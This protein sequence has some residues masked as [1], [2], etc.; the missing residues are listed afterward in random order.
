[1]S[2]KQTAS[3]NAAQD[4]IPCTSDDWLRVMEACDVQFGVLSQNQDEELIEAL[5]HR[6]DWSVDFEGDGTVIFARR[7]QKERC[8]E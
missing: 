8:D 7:E 6:A 3:K 5:R 4:M 1:M 2:T